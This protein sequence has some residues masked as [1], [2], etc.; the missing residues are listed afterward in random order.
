MIPDDTALY[1]STDVLFS[2]VVTRDTSSGSRWER[3]PETYSQTFMWRESLILMTPSSPSAGVQA[4]P[5]KNEQKD[6]RNRGG[7]R[8]PGEHGSLNQ[9]SSAHM[10]SQRLQEEAWGLWGSYTRSSEYM[11]WLLAWHFCHTPNCGRACVSDSLAYSLDSSS[12]AVALSC[13]SLRTVVLS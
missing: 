10:G 4:I 8:K 1:L 9:L 5:R 7:R 3:M 6:C 11:L 12:Y 2:P 13:L